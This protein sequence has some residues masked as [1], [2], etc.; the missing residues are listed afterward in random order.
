MFYGEYHHSL[1]NK[2]RVII[3][4]RFRDIFKDN[5]SEKLFVTRG[6]DQCLFL[7]TEEDWK[8]QERRF[9]DMPFTSA[10]SRRF[11]RLLFSGAVEVTVDKQG[12]VLVPN[13]L[14]KYAGI[15]QD[16]VLIGASDRVEIW[17]KDKWQEF[18]ESSVTSFEEIAE[19]LHNRDNSQN[20]GGPE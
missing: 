19:R 12:R 5:Y 11:N 14:K 8:I 13:Y 17:A 6:L 15:K 20:K 3:P 18:Y 7:F 2:D 16:V 10:D 9:R 4:S 1:D